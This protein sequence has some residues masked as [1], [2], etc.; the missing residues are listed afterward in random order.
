MP[1]PDVAGPTEGEGGPDPGSPWDTYRLP[2]AAARGSAV[3]RAFAHW[4]LERWGL[5][6]GVFGD[7][8]VLVVSELVTN[9]VVHAGLPEELQLSW[10]PPRL[11]VEVRDTGSGL[12]RLVP[13]ES[14]E[15]G[16]R[17]LEIVNH[18]AHYWQVV[19]G[20]STGKTVR[21]VLLHN[22]R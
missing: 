10:H 3:A 6:G 15:P 5:D 12:P 11:V 22:R 9:A 19:P 16:H 14:Y 4:C 20:P 2:L 17:G 1:D 8:A 21:A 18:L 13:P 7:D